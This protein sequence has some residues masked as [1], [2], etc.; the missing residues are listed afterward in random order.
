M[1]KYLLSIVLITMVL[2]VIGFAQ[3]PGLGQD[4]EHQLRLRNM[5]LELENRE[6]EL[7]FHRKMQ[8]LELEQRGMEIDRE[9]AAQEHPGHHR[10]FDKHCMRPLLLICFIVHILLAV[11]V[12]KDMRERKSG[13]GI[14]IV[15][16]LLTG[17]LGAL[18]YAVV[19][20]G[21]TRQ[22]KS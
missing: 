3:E 20:L 6:A 18:V 13:S 10:H 2:P 12:Y 21:D 1:K 15:V 5:Q 17:L 8:E 14:W 16:A 9:R 4:L 22:T 11:W 7:N 19:R